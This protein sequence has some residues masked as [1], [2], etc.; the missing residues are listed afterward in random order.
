FTFGILVS[1]MTHYNAAINVASSVLHVSLNFFL[2]RSYGIAGAAGA[3][4]VALLFNSMATYVVGQRLYRIPFAIG[5]KLRVLLIAAGLCVVGHALHPPTLLESA[6]IKAALAALYV[7]L[8][9]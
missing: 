5:R 8:L 6:G 9:V 4:V 3:S 1:K 2:V 7:L